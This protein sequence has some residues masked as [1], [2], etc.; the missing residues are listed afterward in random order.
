MRYHA[1]VI[2]ALESLSREIRRFIIQ[3]Y[4]RYRTRAGETDA[5]SAVAQTAFAR[6]PRLTQTDSR[7]ARSTHLYLLHEKGEVS[8]RKT[9]YVLPFWRRRLSQLRPHP[10]D[11]AAPALVSSSPSTTS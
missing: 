7:V 5:L 9:N 8:C 11:G 4:I 6:S 3:H 2:D 10:W 1:E